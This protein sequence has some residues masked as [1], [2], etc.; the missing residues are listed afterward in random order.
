MTTVTELADM[1]AA[2]SQG[3]ISPAMASGRMV[4]L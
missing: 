4:M 1:P 2:A 3:T